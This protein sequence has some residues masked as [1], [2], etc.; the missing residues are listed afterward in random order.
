MK[1]LLEKITSIWV[2]VAISV[3]V[4]FLIFVLPLVSNFL[5]RK[6]NTPIIPDT[7]IFYSPTI[8]NNLAEVY[9]DEGIKAFILSKYTFDIIWPLAYL[10]SLTVIMGHLYNILKQFSH[11]LWFPL[12]AF[13][14]DITENILLVV[15]FNQ[16]PTST[17][18]LGYIASGFTALKWVMIALCLVFIL[19]FIGKI[20]KN[21]LQKEVLNDE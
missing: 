10:F 16:Y 9:L 3:L 12:I 17:G 1:K 14:S 21:R 13:V 7:M 18:I 4:G 5:I 20:R 8:L 11:A 6:L 19:I 2:I 15:F